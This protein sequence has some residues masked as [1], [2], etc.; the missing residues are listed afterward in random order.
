LIASENRKLGENNLIENYEV[1]ELGRGR[2]IHTT[3]N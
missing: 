1:L 3:A 2:K